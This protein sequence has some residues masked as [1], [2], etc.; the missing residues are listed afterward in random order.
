MACFS[1]ASSVS[2]RDYSLLVTSY[3]A[4]KFLSSPGWK[5][6]NF[7]L[8]RDLRSINIMG[9]KRQKVGSFFINRLTLPCCWSV[10]LSNVIILSQTHGYCQFILMT[11]ITNYFCAA[12]PIQPQG[13]FCIDFDHCVIVIRIQLYYMRIVRVSILRNCSLERVSKFI[14]D[15]CIATRMCRIHHFA[16]Y[17]RQIQ[18][19]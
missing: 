11:R 13:E 1:V 18:V 8:D 10:A 16:W 5:P 12:S 4:S 2:F 15:I 19:T 14:P 17:L 9:S 6:V 3:F 7:R